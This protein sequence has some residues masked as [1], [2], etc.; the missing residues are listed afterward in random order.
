MVSDSVRPFFLPFDLLYESKPYA[1]EDDAIL[2]LLRAETETHIRREFI[3]AWIR[4][5]EN[6]L[7]IEVSEFHKTFRPDNNAPSMGDYMSL[8]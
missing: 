5:S 8:K 6:E 3:N 1:W 4:I 2:R 7:L